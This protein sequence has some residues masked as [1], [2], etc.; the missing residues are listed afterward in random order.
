MIAFADCIFISWPVS[1]L[2]ITY[3][4]HK[5]ISKAKLDAPL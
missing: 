2:Y 5:I 4:S 3:K 1:F